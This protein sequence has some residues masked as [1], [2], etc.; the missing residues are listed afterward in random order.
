[1]KAKLYQVIKS[2]TI[3]DLVIKVNEAM[4]KTKGLMTAGGLMCMTGPYGTVYYQALSKRY[5]SQSPAVVRKRKATNRLAALR[6][7]EQEAEDE[8]DIS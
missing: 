8:P 6:L 3:D 2:A 1:M 4:Q 7:E 5:K